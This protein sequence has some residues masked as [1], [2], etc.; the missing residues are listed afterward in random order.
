M[1]QPVPATARVVIVGG[2]P[3]GLTFA[4]E[5]AYHGVAS[6]VIEPR[7]VVEHSRPRAK[8]TSARSMELLRRLGAA[9]EIRRRAALPVE[10][11]QDVR[12]C[13]TAAGTEIARMGNVLGLDLVNSELT[14]EAAQQVSQPVVEEALRALIEREP[15]VTTVFGAHAV[16]VELGQERARVSVQQSDGTEQL[17]AADYVVGADGSRSVVRSAMGAQ[18]VG[19]PGGRPNVNITF[20]SRELAEL[21]PRAL[22]HWVLNPQAPG[23]VGPLDL[24]G[25]WWAIATGVESIADDAE[26]AS[27]VRSL[28]GVDVDVE[29]LATDP[30]QARM[31]LSN[32]YGNA[33]MFL[34]GDAA[35]QN[36]PWGGHGFNTGLGDA[37]NLAWKLGAVIGGWAP[38]VLLKS[39]EAERRPIAEQTIALAASNMRSLSLDLSSPEL[40][41]RGPEGDSARAAAAQAIPALKRAEFHSL[42]LVLGYGYGPNS[43][44]Q[45]AT[46]DVYV[47]QLGPGNRLPHSRNQSGESLFDLLGPEFTVLGKNVQSW[48][49][50]ATR[51]GI[52]L[53]LIDPTAHGFPPVAADQVVLVR[54]DQHI[55][56]VGAPTAHPEPIFELALRG[57]T[58]PA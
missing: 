10:W 32:S 50:A 44:A 19:A 4:L 49:R 31:L 53:T 57:F 27:V 8:T 55:A 51:L 24:N 40:M 54:P 18:Y 2:G 3:V 13:T 45:A 7:T 5:L 29:I 35:H 28:V 9:Q 42:G 43:A 41:L 47:P 48:G 23:V 33:R 1:S 39:Y 26:A 21:V 17:I 58:T 38:P 15:L 25:T 34:I 52:P 11:S 20:R 16:A 14:S 22:H 6:T 30:W 46:T 56:W 12:F 37:V 36:P